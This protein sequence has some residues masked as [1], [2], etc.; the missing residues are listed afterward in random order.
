VI[1][2]FW[3]QNFAV[4]S[5]GVLSA[6]YFGMIGVAWAVT[7][8]FTRWGAHILQFMGWNVTSYSYLKIINFAGT[9]LTRIDGLMV[10]GMFAG[11]LI[12]ALFGL[13]IGIQRPM[14]DWPCDD[15]KGVG[16]GDGGA[17]DYNGG[18]S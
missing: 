4:V 1:A 10:I 15:G 16:L 3:N 18:V 12:S 14:V 6:L 8:E 2:G 5:L 11:A 17:N 13:Y 9:P 7:G